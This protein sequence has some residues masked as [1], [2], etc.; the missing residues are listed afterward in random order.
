[1]IERTD[2]MSEVDNGAS[3]LATAKLTSDDAKAAAF[4]VLL[5]S[6]S[7]APL[8]DTMLDTIIAD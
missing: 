4:V 1:M 6:T 8:D 3:E 5:A 7:P 2:D